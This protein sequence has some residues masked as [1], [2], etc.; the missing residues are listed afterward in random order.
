MSKKATDVNYVV[1]NHLETLYGESVSQAND[2]EQ[3]R[4]RKLFCDYEKA[5]ATDSGDL[6]CTDL[7]KHDIPTGDERLVNQ[8]PRRLP[9]EQ[10]TIIRTE[11]KKL[12][13]KGIIRPSQSQYSSNVVLVKKER[14]Y[15]EI[16]Y[17]LWGLK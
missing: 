14:W 7:I 12:A 3:Y 5:F 8:K 15:L 16:M 9:K 1:P 2:Y 11:I 10:H 17:W 6:G 4:L 13:D